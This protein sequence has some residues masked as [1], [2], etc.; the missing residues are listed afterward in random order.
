MIDVQEATRIIQLSNINFGSIEVK[1]KDASGHVLMENLSADRDFP[2]FDRV[3]MD[4]IAILYASFA[5]GQI[6][7][8][9]EGIAAAGGA[10]IA[11]QDP[12]NCLEV[13]TGA[14]MPLQC[15][16]VIRYEDLIIEDGIAKIGKVSIRNGQNVH[17][18]GSDRKKGDLLL[19]KGCLIGATEVGLAA[20]VGKARLLV[21]QIPKVM[22]ISTGDELIPVDASPLPHQIRSSNA[23]TIKTSLEKLPIKIDLAHLN[24]DFQVIKEK[25]AQYIQDYDVLI[26]SGGVSMGKFDFIPKALEALKV[27]KLFHKIKQRPGKPFW[28]G[29]TESSTLVFALPGNPVS[30]FMCTQRYILP[31]F[32]SALNLKKQAGKK[33]VLSEDFTF[34][35]N[36]TYFLQVRLEY[37]NKGAI[38]A[39]PVTGNG[40]GDLANLVK[41]D[42]FL[43]LPPGKECYE[44]GAVFNL[45][46]YR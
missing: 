12:S 7:F 41:A 14:I 39:V 24:D 22:V 46:E 21:N 37:S 18:K 15:D 1:L 45:W 34:K 25:L 38:M 32:R 42:A 11:L 28:F 26:L 44:K 17:G 5:N 4:G 40:S 29:R 2:P 27:E 9:I 6:N 36:L 10:Q 8:P 23:I 35:P 3:T 16:T 13:M 31:W 30:S 20:T 43:E 33:A 19:E